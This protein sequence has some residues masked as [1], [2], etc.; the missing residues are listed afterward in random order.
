MRESAQIGGGA[1][2]SEAG[3]ATSTW[4]L[5]ASI[6]AVLLV[7]CGGAASNGSRRNLAIDDDAVVRIAVRGRGATRWRPKM[8]SRLSKRCT[9]V[10]EAIKEGAR[11][12]GADPL[13][14]LAIAWVESGFRNTASSGAGAVGVMQLLPHISRAFGC[15]SPR[16][17]VCAAGAA[18]RLYNKLSARFDGHDVYALCAYNAGASRVR[19]AYRRGEPPFNYGYAERVLSAR[20]QLARRGCTAITSGRGAR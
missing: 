1:Y 8:T 12:Q 11:K 18:A 20:D 17:T 16:N 6:C 13:L 19:K 10:A 9:D 4:V 3:R 14:M 7:G 15:S 5:A 2:Q